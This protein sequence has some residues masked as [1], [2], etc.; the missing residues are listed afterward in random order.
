MLGVRRLRKAG[1]KDE[2][3][4]IFIKCSSRAFGSFKIRCSDFQGEIIHITK[5]IY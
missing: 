1:Q 3:G 4:E 2:E 5:E